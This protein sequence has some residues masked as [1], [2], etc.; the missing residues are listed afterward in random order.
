MNDIR[1]WTILKKDELKNKKAD[2]QR[3]EKNFE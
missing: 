2:L 3:L 1:H